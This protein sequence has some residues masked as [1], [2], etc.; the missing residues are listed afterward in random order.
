M[1]GAA[2]VAQL[3]A[4]EEQLALQIRCDKL[5]VPVRQFKPFEDR[6]FRCDFAWPSIWLIVEV[7]GEVHRIK[8]RFHADIEKHALLALAGWTVLR[9]GGR[10][11]RSGQ[12]V[13]W[14]AQAIDRA[15]RLARV[16]PMR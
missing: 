12:A 1:V 7:D 9:V 3:S 10:E 2:E 14:V 5:A 8:T 4:I 11:V 6:K 16:T 15:Q 13:Q